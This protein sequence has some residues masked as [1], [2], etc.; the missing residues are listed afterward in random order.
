LAAIALGSCLSVDAAAVEPT[1]IAR[2][3]LVQ[4]HPGVKI[5]DLEN[6]VAQWA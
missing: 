2:E 4:I 5:A 1:V 6:R 3:L